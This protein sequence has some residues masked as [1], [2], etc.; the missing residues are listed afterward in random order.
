[1]RA[2][3]WRPEPH[4]LKQIAKRGIALFDVQTAILGALGVGV[5][6]VMPSDSAEIVVIITAFI[7]EKKQ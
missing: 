4:L 7:L 2:G 6:L 1:M 5:E 3:A